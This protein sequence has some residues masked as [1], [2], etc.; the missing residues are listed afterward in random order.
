MDFDKL[1]NKTLH[2]LSYRPRSEKEIRNYLS[3][4]T[5]KA[6]PADRQ[7]KLKNKVFAK[8][9]EQNLINDEEFAEWWIDQRM[10]FKPKGKIALK[11]E[12]LQKGIDREIVER[13]LSTVNNQQLAI[14][15]KK[16]AKKKI[17]LY[18]NLPYLKKKK[19]LINFLARRGFN[20]QQIHLVI[21]EFLQK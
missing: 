1:Y 16:I 13:K 11:K 9:R 4:K 8:L 21:D 19:R 12:L 10:S 7:E 20:W 2:F 3:K 14:L 15:A 18:E 17:I 5:K 6:L